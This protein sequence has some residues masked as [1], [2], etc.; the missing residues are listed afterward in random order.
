MDIK[1]Q[2]WIIWISRSSDLILLIIFSS[3]LWHK[4]KK[5]KYP[6]LNTYIPK[7]TSLNPE[8]RT[9]FKPIFEAVTSMYTHT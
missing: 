3:K 6:S 7:F 9:V 1:L 5:K 8:K 2:N 4:D